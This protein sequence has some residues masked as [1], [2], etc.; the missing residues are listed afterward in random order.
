MS[1]KPRILVTN[2]S[3][4]VSD[5]DVK[6]AVE[7]L[8]IQVSRDFAPVWGIDATLEF[9]DSQSLWVP[10]AWRV[11]ILDN[12]DQADALGYHDFTTDGMPLGKVFAKTTLDSKSSWTVCLSHE[13]LEMLA[14]P[15][16]I[17]AVF[18]QTTRTGGMLYAYEV[19]DA[20]EDDSLGY[21][22]NGILVSDF[23]T[24]AWFQPP[25][26]SIPQMSFRNNVKK[27]FELAPGGYI[28]YF[29]VPNRDGWTQRFADSAAAAKPKQ[30]DARHHRHARR[31]R[32]MGERSNAPSPGVALAEISCS[33]A[34]D[35]N[36]ANLWSIGSVDLHD[37]S[38]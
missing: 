8:Q 23:V 18:V 17:R 33:I 1:L 16:I 11:L 22:I 14:D 38:S 5:A 35:P 19:C 21:D 28:S 10:G 30:S 27:P 26:V 7:A 37:E 13:V 15:D 29:R 34:A 24:P 3:N 2:Q 4:V 20:V 31:A 12:A 6:L 32:V 9:V 36:A 25:R